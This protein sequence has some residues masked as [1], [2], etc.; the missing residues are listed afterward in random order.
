MTHFFK[1]HQQSKKKLFFSVI[2]C[3]LSLC[4]LFGCESTGTRAGYLDENG[5]TEA[6]SSTQSSQPSKSQKKHVAVT[7]DD[8]PNYINTPTVLDALAQYGWKATFFVVGHRIVEGGGETLMRIAADGHEIG[9]HGY[10]HTNSE[11]HYYDT[12]SDDIYAQEISM[13]VDTIRTY[14]PT[15]QPTL[16]RPIGGRISSERAA[17]SPYS[18]I[19]WSIDTEDWKHKYYSGIPEAEADAR[20][21][22]IVQNALTGVQDGDIILL[23]DIY[24]S[25]ADATVKIFAS[26]YEMGFDVVTVSEL[27]GNSRQAGKIYSEG[28]PILSWFACLPA[29]DRKRKIDA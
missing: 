26:L 2:C 21:N 6:P 17:A 20:V 9:I 7:F 5:L 29:D 10:T 23:H 24:Q 4:F 3:L 8:G 25:S 18:I 15:Y 27:L 1:A 14:V 28:Q 11:S 19:L 13:T 12:C 16:M 22:T